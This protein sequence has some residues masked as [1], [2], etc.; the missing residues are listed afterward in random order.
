MALEVG[1][2]GCTYGNNY[3]TIVRCVSIFTFV[4]GNLRS[5]TTDNYILFL[6]YFGFRLLDAYISE[7]DGF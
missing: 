3:H 2:S 4:L 6:S 7:L 5:S 1:N